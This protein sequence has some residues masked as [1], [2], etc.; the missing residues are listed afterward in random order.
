MKMKQTIVPNRK[1]DYRIFLIIFGTILI[2]TLFLLG[3][4]F[5]SEH[6]PQPRMEL[7][8]PEIPQPQMFCGYCHILTYP[9]IVQKGY[10]LWKKGKH[11]NVGCVE[12]HYPPKSKTRAVA[13]SSHIS[14]Q[15]PGRFSFISLGGETIRT[16]PRISDT[17]CMTSNCHGNP[18]DQF[19]TKKIKFTE[20]VLFVHEPHFDKKKQ[21]EGMQ[22][23]CTTC[24][25]HETDQKKFEVSTATC[26]LCHFTN[27]KFNEDRGRCELCHELPKKP[28]QTSGDKPITHQILKDAGVSCAG[29]HIELIQAA[30]GGKYEAYFE[31]GELKTTLVLGAGR[32]KKES[33]LACHDQAQALKEEKNKKLMHEKHVT[34]KSARCFDCHRPITHAKADLSK[35]LKEQPMRVGCEACHSEPHR[36]QR[37]LSVGPKLEGV[38]QTPD[39]MFKARTNCLGCHVE[40]KV[41]EKGGKVLTAS[42]KTCVRCHTKNHDKMLAEWK[43]DLANEI[44][45]VKEVEQEAVDALLEVKSELSE[46]KLAEAE[47]ML[48][49]GRETLNIVQYGNGVHNKKYSI[50]LID[51]AITRFEDVLDFIEE[52]E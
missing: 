41:T 36:Y 9:S 33:C 2:G 17:S 11:S 37:F 32:M 20:K 18:D 49:E 52:G 15:P 51:A 1:R 30:G 39:F 5:G 43:T 3:T 31:N 44:K 27:V 13:E 48:K 21:I 40:Q 46:A 12:C 10:T 45:D 24:H 35:P 42:G 26:H 14:S 22:V 19:K 34:I 7:P 4:T 50:M 29:C 47:Q 25:Q 8:P 6:Q 16:K 28:I 38:S 23:N